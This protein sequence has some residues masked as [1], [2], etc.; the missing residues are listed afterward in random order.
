[1]S[2][3][4]KHALHSFPGPPSD[5]LF[6]LA[7]SPKPKDISFTVIEGQKKQQILTF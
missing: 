7:N 5:V 3:N 6:C 1:M 2:Q 4:M